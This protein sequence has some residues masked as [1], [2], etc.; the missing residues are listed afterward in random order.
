MSL[1][2]HPHMIPCPYCK[3]LC[4]IP[5]AYGKPGPELQRAAQRGL[6]ELAGCVTGYYEP[7]QRCLDCRKGWQPKPK[8]PE[9]TFISNAVV[10]VQKLEDSV[11]GAVSDYGAACIN[12]GRRLGRD[13]SDESRAYAAMLESH[14]SI[15]RTWAQFYVT[16]QEYC[17]NY[18]GVAGVRVYGDF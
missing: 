11:S 15:G 1:M 10:M 6:V 18:A 8:S 7:T 16:A 17:N 13:P 4:T 9:S 5:I 14:R 12:Y 2:E 3:S